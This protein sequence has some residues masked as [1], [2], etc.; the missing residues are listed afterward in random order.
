MTSPRVWPLSSLR[1]ARRELQDGHDAQQADG[2]GHTTAAPRPVEPVEQERPQA[3]G[4]GHQINGPDRLRRRQ[5]ACDEPVREMPTIRL[6]RA[7]AF[8][9]SDQDD[10]GHVV[11]R[12]RHHQER[13]QHAERE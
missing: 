3:A 5:A 11:Q 10:R 12:D 13:R 7:P 1:T 6:E 2:L 9:Q 4:E 8:A